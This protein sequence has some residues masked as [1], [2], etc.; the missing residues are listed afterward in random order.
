METLNETIV[1]EKL[2]HFLNNLKCAANLNLDFGFI[3]KTIEDGGFR[4]F[5]AHENNTLLDRVKFVCTH[6]D[7]SKLKDFLNKI[8]VIGSCNREKIKTKWMF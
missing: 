4:Y 7:L 2:H 3:L 6:E 8:D 1:N 5:H